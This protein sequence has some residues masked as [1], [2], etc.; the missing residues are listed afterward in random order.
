[1]RLCIFLFPLL[2]TAC[3]SKPPDEVGHVLATQ[4]LTQIRAYARQAAQMD[5]SRGQ[6]RICWAGTRGTEAVG[7]PDESLKRLQHLPRYPLP[8]G[9]TDPL[10][11]RA[12]QFARAYNEEILRLWRPALKGQDF[13]KKG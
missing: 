3:G 7:I 13:G 6:P 12:V 11:I 10:A 1:M 9:C 2:L 4:S 5:L 8:V